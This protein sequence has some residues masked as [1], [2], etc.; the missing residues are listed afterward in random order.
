MGK[1]EINGSLTS[2]VHEC[3]KCNSDGSDHLTVTDI[4]KPVMVLMSGGSQCD[5]SQRD[6]AK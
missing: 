5:P 1:N 3:P 4:L 6:A 2:D